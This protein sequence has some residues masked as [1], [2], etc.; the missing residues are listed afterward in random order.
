[1]I[2]LMIETFILIMLA[3]V[4]GFIV[5]WL[6]RRKDIQKMSL[7]YEELSQQRDKILE[8]MQSMQKERDLVQDERNQS[9]FRAQE[10]DKDKQYLLE[11]IDILENKLKVISQ[12]KN[13]YTEHW[14]QQIPKNNESIST[15]STQLGQERLDKDSEDIAKALNF[16]AGSEEIVGEQPKA[17]E[18]PEGIL[19]DLKK[20]SGIGPKIESLLH[21]L[22]IYQFSQIANFSEANT[23]WIDHYLKFK[24]RIQRENWIDQAKILASGHETEFSKRSK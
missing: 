24:G 7:K 13:K 5:A 12:D 11:K 3:S 6:L 22:G 19:D 16:S 18:K 17:L 2:Y 15:E 4:V 23:I 9:M 1:M 8:E 20:I 10:C 14:N 21:N